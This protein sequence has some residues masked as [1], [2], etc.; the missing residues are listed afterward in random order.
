MSTLYIAHH[1]IKGQEWGVRNGPPYPLHKGHTRQQKKNYKKFVKDFRKNKGQ[2]NETVGKI[3]NARREV[4]SH[5]D[6]LM[7]QRT[8]N[9]H[10]LDD[11]EFRKKAVHEY[12]HDPIRSN[13]LDDL[14]KSEREIFDA[15]NSPESSYNDDVIEDYL[16]KHDKTFQTTIEAYEK[17]HA[18]Y[19]S[20]AKRILSE[21]LGDLMDKP[22]TFAEEHMRLSNN[23]LFKTRE[24][25]RTTPSGAFYIH[26]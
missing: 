26:D 21:D 4:N 18:N 13:R 24:T 16:R 5:I 22:F 1:G 19:Q 6:S 2:A 15:L 9:V 8:A 12:V 17:A 23:G 14:D 10:K 7:D 11:L 25:H 3:K 20:E